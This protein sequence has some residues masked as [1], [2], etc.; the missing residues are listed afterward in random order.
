MNTKIQL[1][2]ISENQE[3]STPQNDVCNLPRNK[4]GLTLLFIDLNS[5]IGGSPDW[6][7]PRNPLESSRVTCN[8]CGGIMALLLQL[9]CPE[10]T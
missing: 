7:D 10:G 3:T 2:F 4:I 6:L 8:V 9:Y 5:L 1:A